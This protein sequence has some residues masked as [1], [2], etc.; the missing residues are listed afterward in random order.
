MWATAAAWPAARAAA[1]DA[2]A[3]ACSAS[4]AAAWA[5]KAALRHAVIGSAPCSHARSDWIAVRG[6]VSPGRCF[7]KMV[8]ARSAHAAA[9]CASALWAAGSGL[10]PLFRGLVTAPYSHE[11]TQTKCRRG[12]VLPTGNLITH[13]GRCPALTESYCAATALEQESPFHATGRTTNLAPTLEQLAQL[14]PATLVLMD[15]ASSQVTAPVSC[16]A[17][18]TAMRRGPANRTTAARHCGNSRHCS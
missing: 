1:T 7:S 14:A 3:P 13:T 5:A 4:R 17:W 15:G 12:G 8:N 11:L 18:P 2:S 16:G 9:Q 6:R 10:G